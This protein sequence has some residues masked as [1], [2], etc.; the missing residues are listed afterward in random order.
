MPPLT[1]SHLP[2]LPM[3]KVHVVLDSLMNAGYSD[4]HVIESAVD[5][6]NIEGIEELLGVVGCPPDLRAAAASA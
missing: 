3:A 4:L 2:T 1:P 6:I 5:E